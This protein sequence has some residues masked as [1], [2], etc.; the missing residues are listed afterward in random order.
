MAFEPVSVT[1]TTIDVDTQNMQVTVN[2]DQGF[3]TNFSFASFSDL[4]QQVSNQVAVLDSHMLKVFA[5][6]W[7]LARSATAQQAISN[8][9]FLE[10]KTITFDL[11]QNPNSIFQAV[12]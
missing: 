10:G 3:G 1:I 6:G 9:S 2:D 8:K 7:L 12:G 5:L 4:R 11:S